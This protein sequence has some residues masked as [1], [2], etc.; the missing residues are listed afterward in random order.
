MGTPEFDPRDELRPVASDADWAI[1]ALFDTRRVGTDGIEFTF[2]DATP[3]TEPERRL[4]LGARFGALAASMGKTEERPETHIDRVATEHRDLQAFH[5]G[6][7][8][9]L[10]ETDPDMAQIHH[11]AMY[12]H[13]RQA[14]TLERKSRGVE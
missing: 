6:E 4:S 7:Y 2:T 13:I 5:R 9:R 12:S 14:S 11:A 10:R 1:Q 8:Y 3:S